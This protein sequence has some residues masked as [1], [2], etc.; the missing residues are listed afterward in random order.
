MQHDFTKNL[1]RCREITVKMRG[2]VEKK[3]VFSVKI[4]YNKLRFK[5]E[6]AKLKWI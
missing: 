6:V 3:Q 1:A 2:K 4:Y 5:L